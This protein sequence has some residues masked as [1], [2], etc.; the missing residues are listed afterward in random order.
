MLMSIL[1]PGTLGVALDWDSGDQLTAPLC[2]STIKN[3]ANQQSQNWSLNKNQDLI[4]QSRIEEEETQAK[5]GALPAYARVLRRFEPK[6]EERR[7][8][9][10]LRG[11]FSDKLQ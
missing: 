6:L 3:S 2:Q 4:C 7:R 11:M 9:K 5:T 1:E 10:L 8:N